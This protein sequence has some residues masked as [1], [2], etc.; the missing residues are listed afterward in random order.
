[1]F[2]PARRRSADRTGGTA[3]ALQETT[4][5]RLT[6]GL[7]ACALAAA[8][9]C[10]EGTSTAPPTSRSTNPTNA[11][12]DDAARKLTVSVRGN[13]VIT[14]DL[15]DEITVMIDRDNFSAPVDVKFDNLPKG[16]SVITKE[17]TI[18]ADKDSLTVTLK[19]GPEAPPVTDHPAKVSA[20]ATDM[21]AAE[22]NFKLSVKAK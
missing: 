3:A 4:M 15:T 6:T 12:A 1:M 2:A 22:T 21:P 11:S 16:V 20:S 7:A 18:P 17:M 5:M 8:V 10:N 14:Q 13:Q 9:G 19:A